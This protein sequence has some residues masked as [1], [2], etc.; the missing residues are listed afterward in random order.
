MLIGL[1]RAYHLDLSQYLSPYGLKIA[2]Q[3][4]QMCMTAAFGKLPALTVQQIMKPEYQNLRKVPVFVRI[5]N[6]QIMGTVPG[7]PRAPFLL[8]VGN[9]DGRGDGVM[10]AGDVE[11]L[12]YQY[13]KAG[14]TVQFHEYKGASHITAGAFF[15]PETGPFLQGRLAGVPMRGNCASVGKGTSIAPQPMP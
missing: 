8:G 3:L 7:H 15:D 13:C 9:M 1:A 4:D 11:A 2:R 14:V 10:Q 5:L 12:A 6:E